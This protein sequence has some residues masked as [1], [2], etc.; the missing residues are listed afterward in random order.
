MTETIDLFGI[1]LYP[2]EII[3]CSLLKELFIRFQ[4]EMNKKIQQKLSY[5]QQ[6][7]FQIQLTQTNNEIKEIQ[8]QLINLKTQFH[9]IQ[10]Q[11]HETLHQNNSIH[12]VT[13]TFE[14][15]QDKLP[16]TQSKHEITNQTYQIK[17]PTENP[18][19]IG[20]K[21]NPSIKHKN[22]IKPSKTILNNTN[23]RISTISEQRNRLYTNTFS[24][25]LSY[26][27]SDFQQ[28][29]EDSRIP[30]SC[31]TMFQNESQFHS[32][33]HLFYSEALYFHQPLQPSYPQFL[34]NSTVNTEVSK[35]DI[36]KHKSQNDL[37]KS[38]P[39]LETSDKVLNNI[40]K[41]ISFF[42]ECT[43]KSSY[44]ILFDSDKL[45]D[46]NLFPS[47]TFFERCKYKKRLA[48]FICYGEYLFGV[49]Y[50][51][52]LIPSGSIFGISD[53]LFSITSPKI[54]EYKKFDI[55][56]MGINKLALFGYYNSTERNKLFEIKFKFGSMVI[57]SPPI[58]CLHNEIEL[59]TNN[60]YQQTAISSCI[61]KSPFK[62]DRIISI[63][64]DI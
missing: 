54:S 50:H 43:G 18:L 46:T 26:S 42:K 38:I 20:I 62:A 32:S 25:S 13:Q 52:Q 41:S 7:S 1:L 56:S 16:P 9:Q 59:I 6:P 57:C 29:V 33:N 53:F 4:D 44:K 45:K 21:E 19:S 37:Y 30:L 2:N 48:I 27:P 5:H 17:R 34:T 39:L 36:T 35:S 10:T 40:H 12:S 51:S 8:S 60:V 64:F 28:E 24:E 55:N 15:Q 47:Q 3:P 61:P 31:N 11:Q 49:Y 23:S 22:D 63:S 14:N 58:D